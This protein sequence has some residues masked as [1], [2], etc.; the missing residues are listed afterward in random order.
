[1]T[2]RDY[3]GVGQGG[4]DWVPGHGGGFWRGDGQ[5]D[6]AA[7]AVD[8]GFE[9]LGLAGFTTGL[10]AGVASASVL[11]TLLQGS[12]LVLASGIDLSESL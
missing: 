7:A 9:A 5:G 1:M 2:R 8:A 4:G 3:R 11:R 10:C 6:A 12:L